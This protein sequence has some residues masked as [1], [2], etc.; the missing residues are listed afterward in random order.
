[1]SIHSLNSLTDWSV[2]RR[3][4]HFLDKNGVNVRCRKLAVNCYCIGFYSFPT[5]SEDFFDN[6]TVEQE[7]MSGIDTDKV[8]R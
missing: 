1:M 8:S 3:K 5:A 6:L 2:V 7:F 4:A